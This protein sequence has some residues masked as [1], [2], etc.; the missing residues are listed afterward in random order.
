MLARA[1]R[2]SCGN[3]RP[4][5][6]THIQCRPAWSASIWV[7]PRVFQRW[8]TPSTILTSAA[9][10]CRRF[11]SNQNFTDSD[12]EIQRDMIAVNVTAVAQLAQCFARR[13]VARGRGGLMLFGSILGWRD[14]PGRQLLRNQGLRPS[15]GRS[16]PRRIET[17]RRGRTVRSARAGCHHS[18]AARPGTVIPDHTRR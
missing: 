15:L 5:W 6:N 9:V 3:W 12:P 18:A 16:T 4:N 8:S 13:M 17:R 10:L 7:I 1:A 11:G 2:R 14:V